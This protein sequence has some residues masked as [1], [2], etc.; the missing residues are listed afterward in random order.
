MRRF[1]QPKHYHISTASNI[2]T[3]ISVERG[4]KRCKFASAE[5]L[6]DQA[7]QGRRN[8]GERPDQEDAGQRLSDL[9]LL[10]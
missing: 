4:A 10:S 3:K 9:V 6:Q 2:Y 5:R 1:T 7:G 8:R